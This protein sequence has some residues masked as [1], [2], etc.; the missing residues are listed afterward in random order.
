MLRFVRR[1]CLSLLLVSA[2]ASA[3]PN[4]SW[5]QP[6]K[7]FQ[8]AD[9][10][11]YV[12]GADLAAFL[13]TTPAGNILIN[14]NYAAEPTLIRESVE[15]LGFRWKDT[16][17]LLNGQAHADH[18]GG[19]AGVLRE[20]GARDMVMAGDDDVVRS[21]GVTDFAFG[22]KKQFA[23]ARVDRVLHDGDAVTLGTPGQGGVVLT[24]HKTAG[25]TRGC[26]TWT[27]RVHL[28]GEPTNELRDVVIVGGYDPLSNY[29]LTQNAKGKGAYPGIGD[30]FRHT[31]A[32]LGSLH[33]DIFLGAHASYF[34]MDAKLAR[35][36]QQGASVWLDREGYRAAV[37]RH[38]KSFEEALARQQV[39]RLGKS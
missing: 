8:I 31:Y 28:P 34:N 16:K 35:M 29:K 18:M 39:A 5:T 12:G 32:T 10:L 20:T 15:Q 21:G 36:P 7:P 13:V 14:A 3:Q 23:P 33:C 17:I 38:E 11:Y 24:A 6:L 27:L 4:A 1:L 19:A 22:P 2:V 37:A 9:N 26:T 30:D 25:H